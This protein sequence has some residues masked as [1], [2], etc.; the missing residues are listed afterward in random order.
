VPTTTAPS[1][2]TTPGTSTGPSTSAPA[3]STSSNISMQAVPTI[4]Q[5]YTVASNAGPTQAQVDTATSHLE[6]SHANGPN[7][8]NNS[9]GQNNNYGGRLQITQNIDISG[10]LPASVDVAK[11]TRD[12]YQIDLERVTNELS[13][14]IKNTFFN[15]LKAEASVNV[16]QQEVT[17][18]TE[19]VRIAQA[20]FNAG[21]AAQFDVLTAETNLSNSQQKLIS[22]QDQVNISRADLNSVLGFNLDSPTEILDTP[23]PFDLKVDLPG[24]LQTAL[25]NRPE[26][27]QADNNI[28]IAKRL[29]KLSGA[30]L[31]PS[32]GL[33]ASANF[34]GNSAVGTPK[35]TYSITADLGLPLYD[36]DATRSRVRSAKVDLASQLVTRDQL[37]QS[38]TLEVR[39]AYLGIVDAQA[40]ATSAQQGVSQATDALRLANVRYQNGIGT[41]LDVTNAQAQL[42]TAQTN[43]LTAQYNYETALAQMQRAIGGR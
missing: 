33:T 6:Q 11:R 5:Q 26:L 28:A 16:Q 8:N 20:K 14:A 38:V 15:L 4:M 21:T 31:L 23:P 9:G 17:A 13:L 27:K 43:L 42:V 2:T 25:A 7:N 36:G 34:N 32:L 37:R 24:N 12:F 30:G 40:L 41:F 29:V 1:A 18:A 22:A 39:Q 35:D 10:L 19:N 3:G